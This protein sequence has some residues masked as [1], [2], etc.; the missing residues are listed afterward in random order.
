M[1]ISELS[2]VVLPGFKVQNVVNELEGDANVATVIKSRR[3]QDFA[4]K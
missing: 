4:A 3:F 2:V 1:Q